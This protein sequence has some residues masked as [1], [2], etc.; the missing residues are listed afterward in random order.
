M[1]R[2]RQRAL[3][4]EKILHQVWLSESNLL[5]VS[6]EKGTPRNNGSVRQRQH[7]LKTILDLQKNLAAASKRLSTNQIKTNTSLEE[8]CDDGEKGEFIGQD[9]DALR[10]QSEYEGKKTLIA[11]LENWLAA[12]TTEK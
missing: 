5:K 8:K 9:E 1:R 11:Y 6:L 3:F 2:E 7:R 4:L 10:R 12:G